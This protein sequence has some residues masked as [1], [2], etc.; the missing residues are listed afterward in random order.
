MNKETTKITIKFL[1]YIYNNSVE[2][3]NGY[4]VWHNEFYEYCI[5]ESLLLEKKYI[6]PIEEYFFK[7]HIMESDKNLGII[8]NIPKVKQHLRKLKLILI[9]VLNER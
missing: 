2:G 4:I 7:H 1:E 9:F 3:N 6:L 5:I 8:F